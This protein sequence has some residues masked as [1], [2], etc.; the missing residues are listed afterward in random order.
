[1]TARHTATTL[2]HTHTLLLKDK[3]HSISDFQLLRERCRSIFVCLSLPR[4][5]KWKAFMPFSQLFFS[6]PPL[7]R[8]SMWAANDKRHTSSPS[9]SLFVFV[10]A[11][12]F[13]VVCH[14]EITGTETIN[15]R[16]RRA[17]LLYKP[18]IKDT[19]H[20]RAIDNQA[21]LSS[22]MMHSHICL[23]PSNPPVPLC[24]TPLTGFYSVP[25]LT[26]KVCEREKV[27]ELEEEEGW[28]GC[29]KENRDSTETSGC[30]SRREIEQRE[31]DMWQTLTRIF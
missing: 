16:L 17:L 7:C 27:A 3:T 9:S 22:F 25:F 4:T 11:P 1:M 23:F 31:P 13:L 30:L 26:N 21:L 6:F 15:R 20:H 8:R 28:I 5:A 18:A 12:S 10:S 29:C 24:K 19:H 2:T 14:G